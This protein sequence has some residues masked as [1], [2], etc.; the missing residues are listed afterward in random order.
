MEFRDKGSP[1]SD[2]GVDQICD[3]LGVNE[4]E[5][6]AVLTVETRGFGFLQDRRPQIL[7]ERHIFSRRTDHKFDSKHPDISNPNAGGYEGGSAEYTRLEKA[8][9]LDSNNALQSASWGIG[10]V[11]G[12]NFE[13]AGYSDVKSMVKNFIGSEDSQLLGM[14]NFIKGNN[15]SSALQ[16][17]NWVSF[18]RGYNGKDFKKNEYDTRLAAAHAKYKNMLPDLSLRSAQAAL[19]YLGFN[20]GPVDGLR[21]RQTRSALNLFQESKG[22][23]VTGELDDTTEELLFESAF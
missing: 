18:A 6:W 5:V 7:F 19:I 14:A 15:L 13:V 11:M 1:L 12:F 8:M 20:P 16:R 23:N 22:L 4:P 10:Q 3:V 2:E 21:G 9:N 17:H